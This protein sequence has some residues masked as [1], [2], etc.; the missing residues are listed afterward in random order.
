MGSKQ[1]NAFHKRIVILTV[2]LLLFTIAIVARLFTMQ[3]VKAKYFQTIAED[4]RGRKSKLTP[5]RGEIKVSD[6][7]SNTPY[8]VATNIEKKLVFVDPRAIHDPEALARQLSPLIGLAE[9]DIIEKI[10]D[11]SKKYVPLK[12]QLSEEEENKI[13]DLNLKGVGF[14]VETVR[15]YPEK[16]FLSQVLGFVGYKDTDRIG[17]YGLE[18]F[19]EK[20][21]RGIPGSLEEE[22]DTSGAWI[23]GSKRD[24]VPAVDGENL[25]LTID[26]SIQF[27]AERII[28]EAVEKNQ[29][30][31]GSISVMNPKTGAIIAM[32]N[33]YSSEPE[34][35]P[36]QY[37][38]VKDPAVYNN[39]A[40]IASY[41]PGSIFKGLTM[42][43]S[44]NEGTV[45]PDTKYIDTGV[46]E[47]DGYKIKNS[48]EKAHGEQTMTQVL[49]QSLNTGV[50]FAKDAIGN[51]KFLQYIKKF[52]FGQKTGIELPEAKGDLSNLAGKIKVNYHTASFGQGIS[53]TPVQMLQAYSA[54]ANHG[55]MVRPYIVQSVVTPEGKAVETEIKEVGQPISEKTANVVSA[56]L[57]NVVENG[58]GKKAAVPGYYVAGK[59]GTAQVPRK[60]GKGY[61][62]NN[63]IGSFIGYA[64]VED[65]KFVM[66]VRVNHPRTVRFA[67]STAAPAFGELAQFILNYYNVPPN[68]K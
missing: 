28:R 55:K 30:D 4:Q 51:A 67:E 15:F 48:D 21:L 35:D 64:P 40:T 63:N 52:G 42:A 11:T 6:K 23:F 53:V 34:F 58:H 26:K 32:A 50:I 61:E 13:A 45:G 60:D 24:F 44:L 49:E 1:Q 56:M 2:F 14:D 22:K 10:S 43:A 68:R 25:L 31:S 12:K 59:T 18:S 38:K 46:V 54:L 41:E 5:S 27:Q 65:P 33:F 19:F 62:A 29:A 47:I 9:K 39:L 36:N 17:L 20:Q 8:A 16:S 66:L 57:V 3:V 37:N 7:F